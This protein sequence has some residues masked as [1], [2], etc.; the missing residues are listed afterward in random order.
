M[1]RKLHFSEIYFKVE[2]GIM[3]QIKSKEELA[4]GLSFVKEK[5]GRYG[6]TITA[7]TS[8]KYDRIGKLVEETKLTRKAIIQI[9]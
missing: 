8:V 3:E 1:N 4:D 6:R 2:I 7:G 5:S 9:L